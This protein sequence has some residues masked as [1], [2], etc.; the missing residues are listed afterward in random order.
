MIY[1]IESSDYYK[2]GKAKDVNKRMRQYA[3]H[4]PDY[5]LLDMLDAP[6]SIEV[7]LHNFLRRW[8]YK[9]EWFY[10]DPYILEQWEYIKQNYKKYIIENNSYDQI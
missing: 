9:T 5:Q 10:K 7:L 4:N 8:K 6:D 3:T 2:I 1:L